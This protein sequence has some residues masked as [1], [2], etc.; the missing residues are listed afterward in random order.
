MKKMAE[1]RQ[2]EFD[3]LSEPTQYLDWLRKELKAKIPSFLLLEEKALL[4]PLARNGPIR[5]GLP[6]WMVRI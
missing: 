1:R 3:A 6:P 4:G 2:R 5:V